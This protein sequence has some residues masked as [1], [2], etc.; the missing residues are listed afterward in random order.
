MVNRLKERLDAGEVAIGSQLRFGSPA[1][2]ELFGHGGVDWIV[3][4]SE[5]APQTPPGIQAQ[6]QAIGNTAATPIVRLPRVDDEQIR[7]YLD[8]GAAGIL[9]AFVNTPEQARQ[10]ARA[11]RYPPRGDRSFGPH[12]AAAYG[13]QTAEY[14]ERSD[15]EVMFIPIIES[16]QAVDSIEAIFAVDGV[17]T[18]VIGAVDLS[19]SLGVPFEFDSEAF[20]T[21]QARV[22]EAA[23]QAGK[24]AGLGLYRDPFEPASLKRAVDEGFRALLAGGDE[25]Y[26]T[27]GCQRLARAREQLR[28]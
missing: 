15:D 8:M 5:H 2:A 19:Y 12:R 20:Q 1:I 10:G 28:L 7:L 27:A 24:P 21:A 9:A 25:P 3:I 17:D 26:L 6:L 23:A 13:L 16:A 14:L 4:D 11:C 22:A 18:A